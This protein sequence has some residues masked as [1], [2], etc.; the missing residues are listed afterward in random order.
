MKDEFWV[1]SAVND[2]RVPDS[3]MFNHAFV[4]AGYMYGTDGVLLLF[5]QT[6]WPDGMYD[7]DTLILCD[8]MYNAHDNIVKKLWSCSLPVPMQQTEYNLDMCMMDVHTRDGYEMVCIEEVWFNRDLIDKACQH[9]SIITGYV[10]S[11]TKCITGD[12]FKLRG[13]KE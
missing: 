10:D 2:H 9:S 7:K 8:Q 13:H 5:V 4:Y 1:A 3:I 11:E 6:D 12:N